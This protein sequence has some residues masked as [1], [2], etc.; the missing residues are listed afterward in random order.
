MATHHASLND[1]FALKYMIS[2]FRY[3]WFRVP[4]MT[5]SRTNKAPL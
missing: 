2:W 1:V 5:Y 4:L 3:K